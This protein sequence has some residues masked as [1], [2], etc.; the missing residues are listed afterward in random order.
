MTQKEAADAIGV[1]VDTL[2]KYER[3]LSWPDVPTIRRIEQVYDTS[4]DNI[5]FLPF[6]YGLTVSSKREKRSDGQ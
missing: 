2:S 1:S 4:Y 5:I 6:D 3:G